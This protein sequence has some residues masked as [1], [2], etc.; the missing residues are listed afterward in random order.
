MDYVLPQTQLASRRLDRV[1]DSLQ[2][3]DVADPPFARWRFGRLNLN[4]DIRSQTE[5]RADTKPELR[6]S[7]KP[8]YQSRTTCIS[9]LFIPR[10]CCIH[11]VPMTRIARCNNSHRRLISLL[12]FLT[13]IWLGNYHSPLNVA[14]D[15]EHKRDY[16]SCFS[17]CRRHPHG[18]RLFMRWLGDCHARWSGTIKEAGPVANLASVSAMRKF[19]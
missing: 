11:S 14:D 4:M 2:E 15:C 8:V 19:Q 5:R 17:L 1:A 16:W 18:L 13:F 7:G 12:G 3:P 6:G 9:R 10:S